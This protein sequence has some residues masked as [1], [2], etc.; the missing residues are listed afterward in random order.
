MGQVATLMIVATLTLGA[1]LAHAQEDSDPYDYYIFGDEDLKAYP[2]ADNA[3]RAAYAADKRKIQEELP[4]DLGMTVEFF[5]YEPPTL[6]PEMSEP[7]TEMAYDCL[8]K[9]RFIFK[10]V[11]FEVTTFTNLIYGELKVFSCPDDQVENDFTMTCEDPN[12]DQ[13]RKEPGNPMDMPLGGVATCAG[14]PI[15]IAS[16]NKFQE[17]EDFRDGSGELNFKRYYNSISGTWTHSYGMTLDAK[18][19]TLLLTYEDGRSSILTKFDEMG[20]G[21]PTEQ[22][23]LEQ[24]NG[25]WVYVTLDQ[26]RYTFNAMGSLIRKQ[27]PNGRILRITYASQPSGKVNVTVTD[28]DGR[29]LQYVTSRYRGPLES[30]TVGD[31]T[32]RYTLDKNDVITKAVK[33]WGNHSTTRN[34]VYEDAQRPTL[35]TGIVDERGVRFATWHYDDLGRAISSEHANGAEKVSLDYRA[36]GSVVVTNALGQ[37]VTYR[38]QVIQG[39]KRVTAIEGEPTVGCPAS[40]SRYTYTDIGQIRT[41]TNGAGTVTA[42][43]YD[44]FGNETR[45]VEAKGT[46]QERTITTTWDVTR[47]LPLTVSTPDRVTTYTY[48]YQSHLISTSVHAIKE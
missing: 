34:Y 24:E 22:G 9:F 43:Q 32:I 5:P 19:K 8:T 26:T 29:T 21:E 16:G 3:C 7:P 15:S 25:L 10:N 2:H 17:E 47:S 46:P 13:A 35:L 37:H 41:K 30:L 45:R 28:S 38:Y 27:S 11:P 36:D 44:D 18:E 31:M 20:F 12:E 39:I 1:S 4:N 6:N 33:T 42:Y 40:N 14:N 48:D 23:F